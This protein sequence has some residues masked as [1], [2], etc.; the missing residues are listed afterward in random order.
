MNSNMQTLREEITAGDL[1]VKLAQTTLQTAGTT[2]QIDL[3]HIDFT[4]Y[5]EIHIHFLCDYCPEEI[6]ITAN[7]FSEYNGY[8]VSSNP[9]S[10]YGY[11]MA[12]LYAYLFSIT[13]NAKEG[14]RINLRM[15]SRPIWPE[16]HPVFYCDQFSMPES[17]SVYRYECAMMQCTWATLNSLEFTCAQN[18]PA[19]CR[20]TMYGL[21]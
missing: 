11:G 14:Q 12:D 21:R 16:E 5:S 9:F 7:Q 15:I 1:W 18:I 2:F 17:P 8:R 6:L 19:G 3:S 20:F 13:P 4:D 10:G